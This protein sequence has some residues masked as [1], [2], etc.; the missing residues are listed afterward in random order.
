[1]NVRPWALPEEFS[2]LSVAASRKRCVFARLWNMGR[3]GA[4]AS[5]A[6]IAAIPACLHPADAVSETFQE[7][8]S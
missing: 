1:M 2:R 7:I 8:E 5:A 4:A 3:R 6:E